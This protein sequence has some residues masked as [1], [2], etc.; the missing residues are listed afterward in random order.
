MSRVSAIA[1][2]FAALLVLMCGLFSSAIVTAQQYEAALLGSG[3][4]SSSRPTGISGNRIGGWIGGGP[5]SEP[6]HAALW[7]GSTLID[8]HPQGFSGSAVYGVYDGRQ[9]GAGTDSSSTLWGPHALLWSG[10]A[11]SVVD[12]NPPG[13][14]GSI[15]YGIYGN[16]QVGLATTAPFGYFH[17]ALWSGAADSFIDLHPVAGFESSE[18]LGVGDG[19]QVGCGFLPGSNL[20]GSDALLWSGSAESVVDLTPNN[21][22]S[23]A[24]GVRKGQ[25]VGGSVK[26]GDWHA[27][28]WKGSAES[29]IDLTPE[30]FHGS[31]A[32][33]TNGYQQAGWGCFDYDPEMDYCQTFHALVWSGN[34]DKYVDLNAFLPTGYSYS[35]A[36]GINDAGDVVGYA[37]NGLAGPFQGVLWRANPNSVPE[38]GALSLLACMG[39]CL[40]G[41]RLRYRVPR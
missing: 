32:K 18:A 15:G 37:Y 33:A 26:D 5:Q 22:I 14:T 8:L 35:I 31:Y 12:L 1:R 27:M 21:H 11:D 24:S 4:L 20:V 40:A 25:Q 30:G 41:L 16:Q 9:V 34:A 19:Q 7:T 2:L 29:V 6:F 3:S 23:V 39:V 17:A 10:N 36:T 28:L 13:Y 38:S